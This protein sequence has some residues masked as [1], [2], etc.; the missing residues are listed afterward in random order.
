MLTICS[1]REL[2]VSIGNIIAFVGLERANCVITYDVTNP[3]AVSYLQTLFVEGVKMPR[4]KKL[5]WINGNKKLVD[6]FVIAAA[7]SW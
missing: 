2:F 3:N 7:F 6:F 4:E 1:T 5:T